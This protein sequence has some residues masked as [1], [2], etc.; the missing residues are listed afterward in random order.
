MFNVKVYLCGNPDKRIKMR[1]WHQLFVPRPRFSFFQP[2][3]RS[4][5]I[6]LGR[7]LLVKQVE[8]HI[9]HQGRHPS[10][11]HVDGIVGIDIHRGQAQQDIEREED[12]E[13]SAAA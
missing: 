1:A 4:R 11:Q 2:D 13:Q 10:A 12:E 9:K 6:P 8:G 3:D 7:K 5:R